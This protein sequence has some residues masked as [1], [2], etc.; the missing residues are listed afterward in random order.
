MGADVGLDEKD[1]AFRVNAG[2]QEQAGDLAD[3]RLQLLG[4]LLDGD[5]V[6]INDAED[7]V[8]FLLTGHPVFD[9]SQVVAD[10]EGARRLNAGKNALFHLVLLKGKV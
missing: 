3:P 5:G 1:R 10:H 8:V 2:R 4:V 6:E 7:I 9:G